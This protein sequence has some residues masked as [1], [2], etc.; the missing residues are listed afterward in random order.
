MMEKT[1]TVPSAPRGE[2]PLLFSLGTKLALLT[3]ALLAVSFAC[4]AGLT[5]M[6]A[7]Q[8][9]RNDLQA[10]MSQT[11][12][13]LAVASQEF[14]ARGGEADQQQLARLSQQF[15][16]E[17]ALLSVKI[18]SFNRQVLA[19]ASKGGLRPTDFFK[20]QIPIRQGSRIVG[21]V[22]A[23]YSP[24]QALQEWTTDTRY[25]L[26]LIFCGTLIVFAILLFALNEVLLNRPFRRLMRAV[27]EA[28]SRGHLV[29]M[30]KVRRG[31]WGILGQRLNQLLSPVLQT[32][33]WVDLMY[34][35]SRL[36]GVP[37]A[38][39]GALES[40]FSGLLYR[41]G[42]SA[43]ILLTEKA[44]GVLK[45]EYAAGL[46][47]E[48]AQRLEVRSG[49]GVAGI[50]LASAGLRRV[51][52]ITAEESDPFLHAV[53]ERLQIRSALFVPLKVDGR[54]TGLA[55]Y[56]SSSPGGFQEP[57]LKSLMDLSD[58]LALVLHNNRRVSEIDS[59]NRRLESEVATTLRELTQTHAR[60][61]HKT[62]ELKTVYDLALA[63][64]ASTNVEDIIRVMI[65][66]IKELVEVSGGAFF[67]FDRESGFLEPFVPA[68]DAPASGV[69]ALRCKIGESHFLQRVLQERQSQILN[70]VDTA[71]QL[72]PSWK[73]V[74]I[75]SILAIPLQ[76]EGVVTGIFCAI[77]KL[78]G[79][80][81]EDDVRLLTL[82][83]SRVDEVLRRL[84]LDQQL[85]Q[86][87]ND[88]SVLQEITSQLPSP[89]VLIDTVGVIGRIT[90]QALENSQLCLFF[91][92][93]SA[94]E[95]LTMV[96]GEWDPLLSFDSRALTIGTSENVPLANVFRENRPA[97]YQR[98]VST[99]SWRNDLLIQAFDLN[100][101]LYLPL[102]VEQGRI[103]VLAIGS[104]GDRSLSMDQRRVAWW[105]AKQVAVIIERSRLYE[106]LRSANEKLEQINTLKNEFI[107]M[108]SHELR[109]PLT[110]IKGFVSIVLNEET[111][112]LNDQQRHFLG[113]SDRAIDRLTLL[114]SDLLDISR[115]EAGQIK[116]QVRPISLKDVIQRA[117][118]SFAPQIKAHG[119][120][121]TLQFSEHVPMILA[122]PDRLSQVFDNL[123]S[124]ALKFTTKG[125]ITV[126]ATDKGD[127]AMVS[128][129]DTGTGIPKEESERIFEKFYQV[130]VGNAWPSKGTG[131]GLAIVRSIIESH[132]GKI[133]VESGVGEG[134]DFRFILP[135]A[136]TDEKG[137]VA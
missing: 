21:W 83:T 87:V 79:L 99:E 67:H 14:V 92:H 93:Q 124:N 39:D 66:G 81:G 10:K 48:F 59:T 95:T 12:H 125:G 77:N 120:T 1:E 7:R 113:T 62:R 6:L 97:H 46:S 15:L 34:Q 84:A 4:C 69:P 11:S 132:R 58:H 16:E 35:T 56:L 37:P 126:T 137:G 40:L 114:V 42:L 19:H 17:P 118:T 36:L 31:E 20:F 80:F 33:E 26:G 78:N 2:P 8:S 133:W 131:L 98:G 29:P 101:L 107:S 121:L 13:Y 112:P 30:E 134:A 52:A 90:R 117:A 129:R 45:A 49:E 110:T 109:T 122:D 68:F 50:S 38:L 71:E 104:T 106:R 27:D 130:K 60:L 82:L 85:R 9:I 3:T 96:G 123:F 32:R 136:R 127:F 64:A 61:G 105:I 76:Q 74:S 86:R 22:R 5:L 70:F 115:I 116:M 102:S 24:T 72:P 28:V 63:T 135:R 47:R 53:W 65:S 41:Y 18:L 103:G 108:V 51:E 55:A 94:S 100:E 89:P 91:V 54:V 25:L 23:W 75:R 57:G 73:A 111:G 119:L 88:L 43:C 44:P 128:V